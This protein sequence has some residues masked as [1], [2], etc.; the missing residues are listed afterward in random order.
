MVLLITSDNEQF[1]VDKDIAEHS[2]MIKATLELIGECDQPIPLYNVSSSTFKKIIEYCEH[3]RGEPLP[4]KDAKAQD[5]TSKR[6]N[7]EIS[8][9][10]QKFLAA[11]Q[12]ML[13]DICCAANYLDIK[14]LLDVCCKAVAN[15]IKGK[16]SEEI[17]KVFNIVNDFT[18]EEEAQIRKENEWAE[19][20]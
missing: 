9:W 16:S 17:R 7:T 11:D 6:K 20:R 10:D 1:I 14:S 3:H 13:F 19:D 2:A 18:P 5:E 12:E 4:N 8:E 15:M